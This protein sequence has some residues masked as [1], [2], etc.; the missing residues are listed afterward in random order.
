MRQALAIAIPMFCAGLT[1]GVL[2]MA[3]L[4]RRGLWDAETRGYKQGLRSGLDLGRDVDEVSDQIQ[5]DHW[6]RRRQ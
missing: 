2:L 3:R 1:F 6:R 5:A 4:N